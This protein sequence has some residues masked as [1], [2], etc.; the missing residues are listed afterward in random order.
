LAAVNHERREGALFWTEDAARVVSWDGAVSLMISE[1]DGAE[2]HRVDLDA[3]P[4][5]VRYDALAQ[6]LI[7]LDAGGVLVERDARLDVVRRWAVRRQKDERLVLASFGSARVAALTSDDGITVWEVESGERVTLWLAQPT[8]HDHG[9]LTV[10]LAPDDR[11]A[12]VTYRTY[13]TASKYGSSG[14]NGRGIYLW[15]LETGKDVHDYYGWTSVLDAGRCLLK[16]SQ[17]G[18]WLAECAPEEAESPYLT[19]LRVPRSADAPEERSFDLPGG[20]SALAFSRGGAFATGFPDGLVAL[21]RLA[22]E[23]GGAVMAAPDETIAALAF[24][25]DD[26][27]LAVLTRGCAPEVFS[28]DPWLTE[29][30]EHRYAELMAWGSR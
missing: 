27:H 12:A 28:V 9:E 11:I 21:F 19:L 23:V 30:A 6:R 25:P 15:D 17:D 20:G 7:T 5:G 13:P 18:Q 4:A 22:D 2:L 16:F 10:A 3:P 26:R 24:S 14:Q 8:W 1:I 29:E